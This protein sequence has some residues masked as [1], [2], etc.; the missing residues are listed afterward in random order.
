MTRKKKKVNDELADYTDRLTSQDESAGALEGKDTELTGLFK[1][2]GLLKDALAPEEVPKSLRLEMKRTV[3]KE[4]A[5]LES[6]PQEKSALDRA[7]DLASSV[8]TSIRDKARKAKELVLDVDLSGIIS[9]AVAVPRPA[10]DDVFAY[11]ADA[12]TDEEAA[13]VVADSDGELYEIPTEVLKEFK[14]S[15]K[16]RKDLGLTT[17]QSG[18]PSNIVLNIS[19]GDQASSGKAVVPQVKAKKKS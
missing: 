18:L 7:M 3:A 11:S 8:T 17:V 19:L 12:S 6:R 13:T 2:V 16:R 5:A 14:I 4:I 1:T 9:E 10:T 15:K